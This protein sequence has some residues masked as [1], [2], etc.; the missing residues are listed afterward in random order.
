MASIELLK[1]SHQKPRN[2]QVFKRLFT[3]S[4]FIRAMDP[5][6]RDDEIR[7]SI[8]DPKE[9]V[10]RDLRL[11][12]K[13][14]EISRGQTRRRSIENV[15]RYVLSRSIVDLSDDYA[16]AEIGMDEVIAGIKRKLEYLS[17]AHAVS[18]RRHQDLLL[19]I[20]VRNC[21]LLSSHSKL[22]LTVFESMGWRSISVVIDRLVFVLYAS[23]RSPPWLRKN[24]HRAFPTPKESS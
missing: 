5:S 15:N 6:I 10:F 8:A 12:V 16:I 24:A 7:I 18:G 17:Q 21:Q 20:D 9:V 13:D 1:T 22:H 4:Q 19:R 2:I 3:C 23:D 11:I 14:A